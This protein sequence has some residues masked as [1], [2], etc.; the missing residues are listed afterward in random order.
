LEQLSVTPAGESLETLLISTLKRTWPAIFKAALRRP[1]PGHLTP[2]QLFV[3]AHLCHQEAQPSELAR[4]HHVGMSAMTGLVDG[5]VERQL[6]ERAPNPRDRRAVQLRATA[7]GR[8]LWAEAHAAV[9]DA[10]RQLLAPL[11]PA[12]RE[13]LARALADL[14]RV[15]DTA[16][17]DCEFSKETI[18][19]E[20]RP[21]RAVV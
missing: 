14:S 2:Q 4:E 15:A 5:L 6:V 9:L 3:L 11:Q 20:Q 19:G 18:N 12:E 17:D 8:A 1:L 21:R 16:D 13:R 7:T 10:A